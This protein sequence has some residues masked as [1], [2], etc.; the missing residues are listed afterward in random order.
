M[1]RI[2]PLMQAIKAKSEAEK[3]KQE[4]RAALARPTR[5]NSFPSRSP[6]HMQQQEAPQAGS[7]M[8]ARQV[9]HQQ[10]MHV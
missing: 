10:V 7:H 1:A 6:G 9:A 3:K 5:A 2:S 8:L 4:K